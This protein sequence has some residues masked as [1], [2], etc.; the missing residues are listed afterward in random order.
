M[1]KGLAKRQDKRRYS[2]LASQINAT[3]VTEG[4]PAC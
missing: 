1:T 4:L 3:V 2:A